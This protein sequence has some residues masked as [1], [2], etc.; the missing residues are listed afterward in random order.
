M[1]EKK[2]NRDKAYVY[3]LTH[4][5]NLPSI[6]SHGL[7]SRRGLQERQHR[8]NDVADQG[9]LSRR[10]PHGLDAYV[11]FHFI[12]RSPFDYRVMKS[13]PDRRFVLIA[14]HRSHARERGWRVLSRHPLAGGRPPELLRWDEG[15]E[16]IDWELMD[17]ERRDFDDYN[18]K[19]VCMAEALSPEP[20]PLAFWA[21]V[22]APNDQVKEEAERALLGLKSVKVFPNM[23]P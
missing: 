10:A 22:Y 4:I 7:C 3:H 18:T 23:F 1:I 12:C 14:V 8:F 2:S 17:Q 13:A 9:I 19:M 15:I 5:D 16:A 20:V 21:N 11:P 6:L